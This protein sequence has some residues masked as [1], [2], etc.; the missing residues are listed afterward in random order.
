MKKWLFLQK[1]NHSYNRRVLLEK[2]GKMKPAEVMGYFWLTLGMVV[3]AGTFFIHTSDQL[4]QTRDIV[5]N[6]I[7]A[8]LLVAIGLVSI[9]SGRAA[10]KKESEA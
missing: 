2:S 9:I 1:K 6:L 5:T 3:L 4:V 10:K 7:G 8:F